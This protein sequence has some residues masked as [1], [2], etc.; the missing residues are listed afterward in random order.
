MS[1]ALLFW[2]A[3]VVGLS[4]AMSPGPV[5]T[6]TIGEAM[7]RGFV[8]GP[9][10]VLGHAILELLLLSMVVAGLGAFLQRDAVK[11]VLG[12][13]GAAVLLFI[14]IRTMRTARSAVTGALRTS[15]SGDKDRHAWKGPVAAGILLSLSNPFWMVWWAT[16]GLG[17]AAQALQHGWLGLGAFY[18][19]HTMSDLAW[20]SAVAAAVAG[21]RRI[22]PPVVWTAVLV[23]CGFALC[24]LG[25]WFAWD[26][27][28]RL[29]M[30]AAGRAGA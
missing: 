27:A 23:L 14:G 17:Y 13:A 26:G 18:A 8:A 22:C 24:F 1:L 10:I 11:G 3:F 19:G 6:A 30:V 4:G 15:G 21:G 16:I 29:A 5:L 28:A 2:S 20:Y 7:K 9:L 25:A 12:L